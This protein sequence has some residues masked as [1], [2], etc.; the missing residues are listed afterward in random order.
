M[1]SQVRLDQTLAADWWRLFG[2]PQID[3][4]VRQATVGNPS[5]EAARRRLV[6]ARETVLS[7]SGQLQADAKAQASRERIN[8][9]GFGFTGFPG[10]ELENPTVSLYSV[11]ASAK[12]DFDLGGGARREAE[13]RQAQ[14]SVAAAELDAAYLT[15]TGQVVTQALAIASWKAQIDA[16]RAVASEDQAVVELAQKA[17]DGGS[18]TQLDVRAAEAQLATDQATLPG[19][20]QQLAVSRHAL[21][22]LVGQAPADWAAPD[23]DIDRI[24]LPAELPLAVPSELARRRPDIRAAEARLHAAVAEVG[25]A[26]ARLY[27]SLTLSADL[28]QSALNPDRIF[29]SRFSGW[30]I[31][32]LGISLPIADRGALKARS[33]AAQA[34]ADAVAADYRRIVLQ[35]FGQVADVLQAIA[36][37]EAAAAAQQRAMDIASDSLRLNRLRYQGGKSDLQ[38]VID[39]QRAFQRARLA[40]VKAQ[41][42][43]YLSAVQLVIATGGGWAPGSGEPNG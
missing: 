20:Q 23:F 11:G 26:E 41:T 12:Y 24:G 28:T 19:L 27:P 9:A 13:S 14:A 21:A 10:A 30:S 38:P 3:A 31:G 42:Q 37:D 8:L 29:S 1:P 18:G 34:S 15:L 5:L 39:A 2:S 7:Q 35:A 32:P 36:H 43:R 33:R 40:F 22:L 4:V 25:V 17:L 6:Q 16:A